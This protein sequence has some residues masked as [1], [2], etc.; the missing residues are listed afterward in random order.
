MLPTCRSLRLK[1]GL[2]LYLRLG[3]YLGLYLGSGLY[4]CYRPVVVS[5]QLL[6]VY[7]GGEGG[8]WLPGHHGTP[9]A[10]QCAH[11]LGRLGGACRQSGGG[12]KWH[13]SQP[14]RGLLTWKGEGRNRFG[15]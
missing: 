2:G 7:S 11:V 9:H 1:L 15:Q 10:E 8:D 12:V 3:L 13:A 6:P 14:I 5:L 4:L